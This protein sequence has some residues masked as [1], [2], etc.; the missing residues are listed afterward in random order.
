MAS[1]VISVKTART[2]IVINCLRLIFTAHR[3]DSGTTP[4]VL[5]SGWT[6]GIGHVATPAG[7]ATVEKNLIYSAILGGR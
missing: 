1:A 5:D 4:L 7:Y 2:R 6:P 3:S